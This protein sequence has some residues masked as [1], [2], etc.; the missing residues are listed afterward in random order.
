MSSLD[1]KFYQP[2]NLQGDDY[3]TWATRFRIHA[4]CLG[5]LKAIDMS[6]TELQQAEAKA[7]E[8]APRAALVEQH[9]KAI[10]VC[11]K[12]MSVAFF[13]NCLAW[14][15]AR[16]CDRQGASLRHVEND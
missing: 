13:T 3:P 14:T 4:E 1:F 10:L 15:E 11:R 5:C 12:A 6:A 2:L 16:Q 9:R 8:G 7:E